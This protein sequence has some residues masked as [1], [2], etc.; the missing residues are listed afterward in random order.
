MYEDRRGRDGS[1]PGKRIGVTSTPRSP[2]RRR[3]PQQ[4]EDEHD[5][6]RNS[7]LQHNLEIIVVCVIDVCGRIEPIMV[8]VECVN[9]L[10]GADTRPQRHE[11]ASSLG[12]RGD[13]V[14]T[15]LHGCRRIGAKGGGVAERGAGKP[16]DRANQ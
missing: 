14:L 13:D 12:C 5:Q 10:E 1:G 4:E 2:R 15:R 16:T 6:A 8:L 11:I 9:V 7:G 3:P